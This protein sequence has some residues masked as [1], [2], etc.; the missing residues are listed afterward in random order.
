MGLQQS[1]RYRKMAVEAHQIL[2][3]PPKFQTP[4]AMGVPAPEEMAGLWLVTA[5]QQLGDGDGVL[6][7][8]ERF[9]RRFPASMYFQS[10]KMQM[11]TVI[12]DKHRAEE[13]RAHLPQELAEVPDVLKGDPCKLGF[14]Y[15]AAFEF[16]QARDFLRTC[17]ARGDFHVF[18]AA[19]VLQQLIEADLKLHDFP[20][21]RRDIAALEQADPAFYR[22]IKISYEMRLPADG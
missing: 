10:I 2:Q 17:M 3:S 7:D 11:D 6:R 9:L 5:E 15:N 14:V 12:N 19:F 13:A 8:G 4:A 20:S 21:A 18:K 22:N 16:K 1:H